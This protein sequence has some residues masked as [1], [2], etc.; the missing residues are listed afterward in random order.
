MAPACIASA[1][2]TVTLRKSPRR[3]QEKSSILV[4]QVSASIST[5]NQKRRTPKSP[6]NSISSSSSAPPKPSLGTRISSRRVQQSS[7]STSKTPSTCTNANLQEQPTSSTKASSTAVAAGGGTRKSPR[8]VQPTSFTAPLVSTSEDIFWKR[9]TAEKV[10]VKSVSSSSS[11][12]SSSVRALPLAAVEEK[13]QEAAK[14]TTETPRKSPRKRQQATKSFRY[15]PPT[16]IRHQLL[17]GPTLARQAKKRKDR[18]EAAPQK[19]KSHKQ[20]RISPPSRFSQKMSP[21]REFG[22]FSPRR[23]GRSGG[24]TTATATT[25]TT[26]TT[27]IFTPTK[28]KKSSE[29]SPVTPDNIESKSK[30]RDANSV[31]NFD[32]RKSVSEKKKSSKKKKV[33]AKGSDEPDEKASAKAR[34][35]SSSISTDYVHASRYGRTGEVL[36]DPDISSTTAVTAS[37]SSSSQPEALHLRC[38]AGSD[39]GIQ[40][41][42][43]QTQEQGLQQ[44]T[45][46][47]KKLR[48]REFATRALMVA[49]DM[50]SIYAALWVFDQVHEGNME[51]MDEMA[52]T[53]WSNNQDSG[54]YLLTK[55][56]LD[57][58]TSP[59]CY[60]G[61]GY[62]DMDAHFLINKILE[63]F[64]S[65]FGAFEITFERLVE[66]GFPP[67]RAFGIHPVLSFIVGEIRS[68]IDWLFHEISTSTANIQPAQC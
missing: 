40:P 3:T 68:K 65:A 45:L 49:Q 57:K 48:Q 10:L 52:L 6:A 14:T 51:T 60:G 55:Y 24:S 38:A 30:K 34:A 46:M 56:L 21:S 59:H 15:S 1:P 58:F 36:Q 4:S 20:K 41:I 53:L 61:L 22:K 5:I 63:A 50:Q 67:H 25:T 9:S 54:T 43:K 31:L 28:G 35:R 29:A 12:S 18:E 17:L 13:P 19:R 26:T 23:R 27:T 62:S 16:V 66:V 42:N 32:S 64:G 11:S 2:R 47:I 37:S 39:S 33:K 44:Q 8:R 7:I